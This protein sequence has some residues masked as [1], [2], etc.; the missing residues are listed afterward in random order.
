MPDHPRIAELDRRI[1]RLMRAPELMRP[2]AAVGVIEGIR[3]MLA[4]L[5]ARTEPRRD[6]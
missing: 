1:D 4:D 6:G 3:A 5:Y 2:A